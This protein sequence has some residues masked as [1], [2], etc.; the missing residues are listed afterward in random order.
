[1]GSPAHNKY[2]D[3]IARAARLT[4]LMGDTRLR[5]IER[6]TSQI[7]GHAALTSAV[8]AWDAYLKELVRVFF[9]ETANPSNP[10]FQ[11]I[12]EVARQASELRAQ[13]FNTPNWENAREFLL[14]GTGFD[15]IQSWIWPARNMSAVLVHER[16]NEILRVRHSFA[17]GLAI[18]SYDWIRTPRGNVRLNKAVMAG[19]EAFFNNLV[20]RTDIG[21]KNHIMQTYQKTVL[22]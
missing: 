2:G 3:A 21:M 8:A 1:M 10:G 11:A 5:P 19:V 12:H 16:L 13:K 15:P 7:L 6:E 14:L 17:H 9:A 4:G 20:K 18:P 22:W